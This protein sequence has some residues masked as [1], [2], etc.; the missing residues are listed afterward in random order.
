MAEPQFDA[1]TGR[2]YIRIRKPEGGRKKKLLPKQPGWKKLA[3]RP[4]STPA[5][6]LAY[7]RPYQ[8]MDAEARIGRPI[9]LP[10][11]NPLGPFLDDYVRAYATYGRKPTTLRQVRHAV[12]SFRDFCHKKKVASVQGVTPAVCRDFLESEAARGLCRTTLVQQKSL[13]GQGFDRAVADRL[14]PFNPWKGLKVPGRKGMGE[15]PHYPDDEVEKIGRTLKGWARDMFVV[16]IECGFR[17][18]AIT[19]L[20]WRDVLWDD[21]KRPGGSLVCRAEHS[22]NGRLYSVPL[23]P[24]LREVLAR[25]KSEATTAGPDDLVFPSPRT[26]RKLRNDALARRIERAVKRLKLPARGRYCHAMRD[27]FGTRCG[28]RGVHPRTIQAWMGHSTIRQSSKYV[29][30]DRDAEAGEIQKLSRPP[31]DSADTSSSPGPGA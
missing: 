8:D 26:G 14:I 21:P 13:I 7:A 20:R 3:A 4:K 1:T 2:W 31:S 19:N 18:D 17:I 12:R 29:H 23:F 9:D 5:E 10:R 22:K 24:K 6:V 25:R 28:A 15:A 11:S 16:G 30:W 27:T